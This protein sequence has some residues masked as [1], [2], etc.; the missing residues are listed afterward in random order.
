MTNMSLARS[1]LI[2]AE[3]RLKILEVLLKEE[4]SDTDAVEA[5]EDANFV[6]RLA[7]KVIS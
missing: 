7:L 6:V 5:I 1:Y 2:K 3:K 4:Y